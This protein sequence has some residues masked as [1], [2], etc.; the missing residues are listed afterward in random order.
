MHPEHSFCV[1]GVCFPRTRPKMI[2]KNTY[3]TK[4]KVKRMKINFGSQIFEQETTLTAYN[5]TP[6]EI[7]NIIGSFNPDQKKRILLFA[8]WDF[9]QNSPKDT[10]QNLWASP[11][12]LR[13]G[14]SQGQH[15]AF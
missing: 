13:L 10:Q 14:I 11:S 6:L 8:H 4:E 3:I 12:N 5:G 9:C 2:N 1:R 7:R 15:Q